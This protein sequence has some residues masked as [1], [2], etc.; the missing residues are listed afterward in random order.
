M[1]F[2]F[3]GALGAI[4]SAALGAKKQKPQEDDRFSESIHVT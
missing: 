2:S 4:R 3:V 1:S